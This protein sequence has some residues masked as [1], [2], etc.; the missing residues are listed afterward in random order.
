MKK[1]PLV[2][3]GSTLTIVVTFVLFAIA[4]FVHGL[5]QHLL[6]E[7]GVF[8]V[9]VKLILMSVKNGAKHE[10]IKARLDRIED[11]L[12]KTPPSV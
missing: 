1:S 2:D 6:L 9:S 3:Y 5:T 7:A 12:T 10:E 8:L 4:V 11:L